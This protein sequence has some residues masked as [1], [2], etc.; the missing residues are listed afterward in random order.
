MYVIQVELF[1]GVEA[2]RDGNGLA[3]NK[4]NSIFWGS[5]GRSV[6]RN[7]SIWALKPLGVPSVKRFRVVG[8]SLHRG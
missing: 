7:I 1:R 8:E 2:R 5:Y 3:P 4:G 6:S